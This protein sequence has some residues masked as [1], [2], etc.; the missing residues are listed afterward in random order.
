MKIEEEEEYKES[1]RGISVAICSRGLIYKS[2]R[3]AV[4]RPGEEERRVYAYTPSGVSSFALERA[5]GNLAE[6]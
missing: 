5:R 2:V 1:A 6:G 3:A 4:G